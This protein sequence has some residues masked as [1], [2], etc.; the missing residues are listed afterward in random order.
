MFKANG[1]NDIFDR[2]VVWSED[3][4]L[5][6]FL[7]AADLSSHVERERRSHF[8]DSDHIVWRK[9]VAPLRQAGRPMEKTIPRTIVGN[10]L[11]VGGE[12]GCELVGERIFIMAKGHSLAIRVLKMR[13]NEFSFEWGFHF[14]WG[15]PMDMVI[16]ATLAASSAYGCTLHHLEKCT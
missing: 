8:E 15:F 6:A 14:E 5:G 16:L 11:E 7:I 10:V 3:E 12:F 1:I 4:Q 2:I 9:S 13:I